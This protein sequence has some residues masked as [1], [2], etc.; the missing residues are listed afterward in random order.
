MDV[1][2]RIAVLKR[3]PLYH[4]LN[5]REYAVI[6]E[7]ARDLSLAAGD[8]LFR[9]GADAVSGYV[10]GWGRLR[11][12]QQAPDGQSVTLRY[13]NP[14]DMVGTVAVFRRIP[15]PATAIAVE[16][17]VALSWSAARI[18]DH[19]RRFPLIAQNAIGVIG[20]RVEELMARLQE[21]A[22]QRVERR[23]AGA[24]ARLAKQSGRLVEGGVEIPFA[25]SRQDLAEMTA[26]TLHTVSRTLS[27]WHAEG[28]VEARRTSYIVVRDLQ[29]LTQIAEES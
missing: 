11:L 20:G 29:R 27:A 13:M 2:A 8:V 4:G 26:T 16:D 10:L 23:I 24:L 3:T 15:F 9:Q 25:I 6:A 7:D 22:T 14:S 19:L 12:V 28:V 17:S 21:I 18:A 5:E 1:H